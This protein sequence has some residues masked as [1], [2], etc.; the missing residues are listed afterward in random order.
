[1]AEPGPA[2]KRVNRNYV[3]RGRS[4]RGLR[5][6][7]L[8]WGAVP[9]RRHRTDANP[10]GYCDSYSYFYCNS[11]ADADCNS[12]DNPIAKSN[13]HCFSQSDIDAEANAHCQARGYA[14]AAANAGTAPVGRGST[15]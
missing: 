5:G 14:E 6:R 10:N 9:D 7:L 4:R 2:R 12:N 1:M 11:N 3:W 15:E 13:S 8:R